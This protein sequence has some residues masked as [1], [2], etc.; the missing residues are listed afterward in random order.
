MKLA[1]SATLIA[2]LA[3]ATTGALALSQKDAKAAGVATVT[4][5]NYARL[6]TSNGNLITNRA[7]ATNTPWAVGETINI[8]NEKYYQVAT[9]EYLKASDSTY[10]N[11]QTSNQKIIGHVDG[12]EW[13]FLVNDQTNGID[14]NI[15]LPGSSWAV[16]KYI[17]NKYGQKYVQISTHEYADA[18][19][20]SFNGTL[21]EPTYI[22]NF[23][24]YGADVNENSNENV[25]PEK[26]VNNYKPDLNK[27]NDYFVQYLN[28]LHAAN[29][30]APVHSSADMIAYATQR[31]D[32]QNGQSLD[33]S[34]ATKNT[35]EN[36]TSAGFDYM[37][38]YGG[39]TSD[40]DAAYFL[41]KDWYD[42]ENNMT[43]ANQPGHYGHRAALIY[44]GPTVGL[45]I[46][47]GDAAFDADWNYGALDQFNQLY[48]YTGTNPGT[49]FI[50]KDAI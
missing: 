22:E 36:L 33:H 39:V 35:S 48:N 43:G 23:A 50:S 14:G 38:N 47:N 9:N 19:H 45:G 18:S 37:I 8:N 11:G 46:N 27:I 6:Y 20:M 24:V 32:Q 3:M 26:P 21:P 13:I 10:S 31:A 16:G 30:T 49:K 15:V 17:V 42:E 40:K 4:A 1:K 5:P 44:S 2:A 34:T 41:L 7:L 12:I 25:E 28:A 29:G